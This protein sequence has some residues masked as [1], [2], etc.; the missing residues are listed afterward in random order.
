MWEFTVVEP[1]GFLTSDDPL[2]QCHMW[3]TCHC[4]SP[5]FS[6]GFARCCQPFRQAPGCGFSQ[7]STFLSSGSTRV[8][9]SEFP[10]IMLSTRRAITPPKNMTMIPVKGTCVQFRLFHVQ[11]AKRFH[12]ATAERPLIHTTYFLAFK[13]PNLSKGPD[14]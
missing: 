2:T 7:T 11:I 6:F 10:V 5:S 3:S 4:C 14:L 8:L 13:G 1:R 12:N 9:N